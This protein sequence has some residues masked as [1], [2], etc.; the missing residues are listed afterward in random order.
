IPTFL[1]ALRRIQKN[2][3]TNSIGFIVSTIISPA[4]LNQIN[5][6]Y[7]GGISMWP[8]SHEMSMTPR[9]FQGVSVFTR[10][11][12][13]RLPRLRLGDLWICFENTNLKEGFILFGIIEFR[14]RLN[15]D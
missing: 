12:T 1:R 7:G 3:A 11:S 2:F 10:T 15:G 9:G 4:S 5:P 14:R 6:C 13:V 8:Q